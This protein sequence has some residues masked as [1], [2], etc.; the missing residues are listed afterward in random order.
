MS[1][2]HPTQ[3]DG[4]RQLWSTG[5][6]KNGRPGGFIWLTLNWRIPSG[7]LVQFHSIAR[8]ED[9]SGKFL[10]TFP[11]TGFPCPVP[12]PPLSP[13]PSRTPASPMATLDTF[14][15]QMCTYSQTSH[16]QTAV[17]TQHQC[18]FM[19]SALFT[20]AR[21]CPWI[22]NRRFCDCDRSCY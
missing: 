12:L 13:L 20:R 5:S 22:S 10:R 14:H 4:Q 21:A 2:S 9:D 8:R 15:P 11:S 16:Q 17:L 19:S 3:W 6:W 1:I 18:L 7:M